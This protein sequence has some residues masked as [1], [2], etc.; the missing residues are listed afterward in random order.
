VKLA[1]PN[2]LRRRAKGEHGLLLRPLPAHVRRH[3]LMVASMR[4]ALPIVAALLLAA[5]ALWSKLG[6][7]TQHFMLALATIGPQKIESMTMSNPHYE[8]IDEKNRPFSVTAKTATQVDKKGDV[9]A[10]TAPEADITMENGAWLTVS[11]D[12][13]LYQRAKQY[14]DLT[15]VVNIFHDQGYEMHTRDVHIDFTSNKATGHQPV[16]GQGP[17]GGLTAQGIEVV[18]GGKRIFLLGRSHVTLFASGQT[19]GQSSLI[20]VQ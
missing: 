17:A 9:M 19:G 8:G 6:L 16:Q 18:D 15:G 5:L 20:P 10:L 7:D 4:L 2:I 14:L 13:G 11:S 3:S 1:V 12:T